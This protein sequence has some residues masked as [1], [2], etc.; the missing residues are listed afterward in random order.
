[1]T[2]RDHREARRAVLNAFATQATALTPEAW[3]RIALRCG[4][5]DQSSVSGFLGRADL[6]AGSFL[7]ALDPYD[8]HP[9]LRRTLRAI[10]GA[11]GMVTALAGLWPT[12]RAAFERAERRQRER[13]VP[14]DPPFESFA[15]IMK[16]VAEQR[17]RHPGA[18]AA[19]QAVMMVLTTGTSGTDS[20][21][22]AIYQPFEPEIPY[23]SLGNGGG[24]T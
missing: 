22:V 5:L 20:R 3:Q 7:P 9:M 14:P 10:G 18:A 19:L 4:V 13:G 8:T 2:D 12:D 6:L 16:L 11:F 1:M 24:P 21:F 15:A 23:G 17:A